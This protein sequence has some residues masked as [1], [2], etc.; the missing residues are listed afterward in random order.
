MLI[1]KIN[2]NLSSFEL[3]FLFKDEAY[4]FFLDSG[5]DHNKLGQY[6]FIGFNP[7]LIFKSK[8]DKITILEKDVVS[9]FKGSP[10]DKLKEILASY[11]MDY[12]TEFPFIGGAVGY[13]G[14][15]LCHHIEKL[16]RTAIDD[17]NIP[18]C[19]FGL[20]DGVIIIDH[21]KNQVFIASLGI[22][23]KPEIVIA[24]IENKI[25]LGEKKGVKIDI[26]K[27][28]KTS[29]ITS[30]FTK[31]Q[32]IDA[33]KKIR[34]YIESGDIYQANMTQRFQCTTEENPFDIYSKL[35]EINP[36][37]FAS[38]MDFGEGCIVSSSPERFI[39]IKNRYIETR[40]IK[41]TCPRGKNYKEDLKN[42]RE[43]LASE[44]DKAELLMIVDL[45]RND[46]GKIAK[47]GT[48][49]VTELFNLE[50]YS[51]VH[52]LVSTIIGEIDDNY[53]TID[54]IKETFPGGSIT[55]APKIRS[56]EI[57]DE[58]EPTQRNIYT[59]SIGYIGFN[60]DV[61]LNIAIRTIVCKDSKAYFQVGGGITWNSNA[62][63][64][65]EETLH[66]AKALIEVFK[67]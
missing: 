3:Y 59:G 37:P 30:N 56:M 20:Y 51:T 33:I 26:S 27:R 21:R 54:C 14:Y 10:F 31:E 22:K 32:Y 50:T 40:P 48:V 47:A 8:N 58:L 2:T 6:S 39:K 57:I 36:A 53:D 1:K 35:R 25:Y 66:K 61:D 49:K 64:E 13:L 62:N 63:L 38:F 16:S 45:E 34:E 19:Y 60:G 43:L 52:H 65:Y 67:N 12:N 42:K 7:F 18:D 15:D 17:V 29:K 23:D 4:S 11:K 46:I 28:F 44:K 55:G 41:G 9:V 5:M 24:N